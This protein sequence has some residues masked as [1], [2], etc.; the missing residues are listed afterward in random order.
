MCAIAKI[1]VKVMAKRG[2]CIALL[3]CANGQLKIDGAINIAAEALAML[4]E[5][6]EALPVISKATTESEAAQ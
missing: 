2:K 1:E 4:A 6:S 3:T 5:H